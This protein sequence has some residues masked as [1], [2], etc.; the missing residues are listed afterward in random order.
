MNSRG[1]GNVAPWSALRRP[2]MK[3]CPR[4]WLG[5]TAVCLF[6]GSLPGCLTSAL[7]ED[8]PSR[9]LMESRSEARLEV[10]LGRDAEVAED[11]VVEASRLDGTEM[12]KASGVAESH[13][14][15]RLLPREGGAEA[16]ALL[17][18]SSLFAIESAELQVHRHVVGEEVQRSD[19]ELRLIGQPCLA[20]L[21]VV[22]DG[23]NLP[24][25]TLH[26]LQQ[27]VLGD[28]FPMAVE[29]APLPAM[30]AECVERLARLDLSPLGKTEG[31]LRPVRLQSYAWVDAMFWPVD[32]QRVQE[33][34]GED[35]ASVETTLGERLRRLASLRLLAVLA[36]GEAGGERIT[37]ALRPDAIWL[38]G[39]MQAV[40]AGRVAHD[41]R[42]LAEPQA[43]ALTMVAES[44]AMCMHFVDA[45]YVVES[46]SVFGKIL[47]TPLA[48]AV[49]ACTLGLCAVVLSLL[50]DEDDD[51]CA[52]SHHRR[53]RH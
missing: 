47:L 11:L 7:W 25:E 43:K 6:L 3:I 35:F 27:A 8:H 16:A 31:R 15:W 30:F 42:W 5:A 23:A 20:G 41:S 26:A 2:L 17:D 21:A 52:S 40:G 44:L 49:D 37:V 50:D 18:C 22:L 10:V 51:E 48:V 34:L 46:D 38:W 39:A 33:L 36:V 53:H 4:R 1:R 24:V 29:R 45:H 12:A 32:A 13:G 19:A 28:A 9:V 14:W